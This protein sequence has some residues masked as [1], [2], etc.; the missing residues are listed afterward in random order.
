MEQNQ[1]NDSRTIGITMLI[2]GWI[3][4]LSLLWI[5]YSRVIFAP[6]KTKVEYVNEQTTITLYPMQDGHYW[7]DGTVNGTKVEFLVDTGS[8]L[9]AIPEKLARS[10]ALPKLGRSTMITA[11]GIISTYITKIDRLIIGGVV[12]HGIRATILPNVSGDQALL[13]MNVLKK[14]QIEQNPTNFIIRLGKPTEELEQPM[15]EN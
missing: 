11:N 12:L 2:I 7:I 4:I 6:Q 9:V 3:I 15:L 10:L 5:L 8:S 1:D 14:F 13:G